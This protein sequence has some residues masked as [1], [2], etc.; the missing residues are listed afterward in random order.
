[1]VGVCLFIYL[2]LVCSVGRFATTLWLT[3]DDGCINFI[4]MPT[5][6]LE[7]EI[8]V[9]CVKI[10]RKKTPSLLQKETTKL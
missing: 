6:L 8:A 3:P 1:M 10:K 4:F 2:F 5:D 7:K 9:C